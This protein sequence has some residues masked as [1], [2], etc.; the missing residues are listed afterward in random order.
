MTYS[1][2]YIPLYGLEFGDVVENDL[3]PLP[4]ARITESDL[5]TL[6]ANFV[7]L[8]KHD[9]LRQ[10][11][12]ATERIAA[13][14]TQVLEALDGVIC[15]TVEFENY[16]TDKQYEQV[17]IQA[18][19]IADVFNTIAALHSTPPFEI[20]PLVS[21]GNRPQKDILLIPI[22]IDYTHWS[23]QTRN[24]W[25]FQPFTLSNI[26]IDTLFAYGFDLFMSMKKPLQFYQLNLKRATH[27]F[28]CAWSERHPETRFM[29]LIMCIE[30]LIGG[31][32]E[33]KKLAVA[34]SR[35]AAQLYTNSQT[36]RRQTEVFLIKCYDA[37]SKIVHGSVNR[38]TKVNAN[39]AETITRLTM[40]AGK[41]LVECMIYH[42][43]PWKK[44]DVTKFID[45]N[46]SKAQ[47]ILEPTPLTA[48][49][50]RSIPLIVALHPVSYDQER[51]EITLESPLPSDQE[52]RLIT[53]IMDGKIKVVV[54]GPC[55]FTPPF[56]YLVELDDETLS[57]RTFLAIEKLHTSTQ[58]P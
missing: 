21:L 48:D 58:F 46:P 37:R 45:E 57:R 53:G 8:M 15:Y 3:R 27:W 44:S 28:S 24:I 12:P 20:R 51:G 32:R 11:D 13:F 4:L 52:W 50:S 41:I 49:L 43:L 36:L 40:I 10:I 42:D 16:V 29:H 38:K 7:E 35:R 14:E 33:D 47:S 18:Q 25:P 22:Q 39:D 54:E 1:T 56:N 9:N 5:I 19:D 30:T 17:Y 6:Y 31:E 55:F 26:H 2:C 23:G 34:F